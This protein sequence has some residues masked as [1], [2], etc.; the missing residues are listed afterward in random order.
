MRSFVW[1]AL[2][3]TCLWGALSIQVPT[4]PRATQFERFGPIQFTAV[5]TLGATPA[6]FGSDLPPGLSLAG[7]GQLSGTPTQPGR[8][9]LKIKAIAGGERAQVD[10]D[11]ERLPGLRKPVKIAANPIHFGGVLPCPSILR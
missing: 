11:S 10:V 5:S 3:P 2:L 7:N 6:F 4:L 9:G 8:F 1:T